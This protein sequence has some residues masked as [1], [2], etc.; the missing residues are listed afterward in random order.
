MFDFA[1]IFGFRFS[2]YL[3]LLFIACG[4]VLIGIAPKLWNKGYTSESKVAFWAGRLYI[5][6]STTLYFLLWFLE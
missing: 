5:V 1:E 6:G 3:T 2:S 4:L